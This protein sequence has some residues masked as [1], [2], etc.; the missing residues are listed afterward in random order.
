VTANFEM[1]LMI[2]IFYHYSNLIKMVFYQEFKANS[3]FSKGL[4]NYFHFLNLLFTH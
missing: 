4:S 1:A 2:T 3:N